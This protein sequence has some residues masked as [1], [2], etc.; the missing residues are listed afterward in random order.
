[1]FIA[2]LSLVGLSGNKTITVAPSKSL[3]MTPLCCI[4]GSKRIFSHAIITRFIGSDCLT[5][6]MN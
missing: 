2:Y 4:S 5:K 3:K 1:M 6:T